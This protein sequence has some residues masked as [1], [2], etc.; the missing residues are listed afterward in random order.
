MTA[1]RVVSFPTSTTATSSDFR[2]AQQY[3]SCSSANENGKGIWILLALVNY[4]K[5]FSRAEGGRW[6]TAQSRPKGGVGGC[7]A[8][9]H[10]HQRRN[11][12]LS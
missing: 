7:C 8:A 4:G 10:I 12:R 11:G 2:V 5:D 3:L 6:L 1:H 9:K